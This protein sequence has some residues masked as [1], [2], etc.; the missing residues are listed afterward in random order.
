MPKR[1]CRCW[2]WPVG[3][4]LVSI[5]QDSRQYRQQ[6]CQCSL[7][8]NMHSLLV[9]NEAAWLPLLSSGRQNLN[10][11]QNCKLVPFSCLKDL[12]WGN[13]KLFGYFSAVVAPGGQESSI[14]WEILMEILTQFSAPKGSSHQRVISHFS[15]RCWTSSIGTISYEWDPLKRSTHALFG[16]VPFLLQRSLCDRFFSLWI[17][18]SGDILIKTG[19]EKGRKACFCGLQ[20]MRSLCQLILALS[21]HLLLIFFIHVKEGL[22]YRLC[23]PFLSQGLIQLPCFL[24]IICPSGRWSTSHETISDGEIADLEPFHF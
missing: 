8:P 4:N 18:C 1:K 3:Q 21:E 24:L 13:A 7:F 12:G 17:V 19:K 6:I 2:I 20:A 22:C 23:P 10:T 9:M 5:V 16:I 11:V 14:L 15:L